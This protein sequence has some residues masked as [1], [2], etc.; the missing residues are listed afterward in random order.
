MVDQLTLIA[1]LKD[2]DI[3]DNIIQWVVAFLF[4]DRNQFVKLCENGRSQNNYAA[5]LKLRLHYLLF[6][7]RA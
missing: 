6:I 5:D 2:L 1:K 4:T 3:A 7:Y